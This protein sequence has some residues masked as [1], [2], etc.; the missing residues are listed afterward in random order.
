[1]GYPGRLTYLSESSPGL[2][3][4]AVTR[5]SVL[6]DYKYYGLESRGSPA[7]LRRLNWRLNGVLSETIKSMGGLRD[8]AR[9]R[10]RQLNLHRESNP[11][12]FDFRKT[13]EPTV[14]SIKEVRLN[15]KVALLTSLFPEAV[16]LVIVRNP[17]AQIDSM[18]RLFDR[19]ELVYLERS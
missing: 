15:F 7:W 16:F 17:L 13:P 9:I 1:R 8:R 5:L 14:W 12:V 6:E 2:E 11:E 18:L 10:Y 3:S 4:R 19:G